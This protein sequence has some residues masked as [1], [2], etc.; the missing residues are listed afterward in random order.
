M[1]HYQIINLLP[2]LMLKS[3]QT[4]MVGH[5]PKHNFIRIMVSIKIFFNLLGLVCS[6]T[7]RVTLKKFHHNG[8]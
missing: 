4:A 8:I 3:Y 5:F 1:S 7:T 6:I 2:A